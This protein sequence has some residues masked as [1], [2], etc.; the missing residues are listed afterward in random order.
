MDFG[1]MLQGVKDFLVG[2]PKNIPQP[3]AE[4]YDTEVFREYK[5][6]YD[7]VPDVSD[8]ELARITKCLSCPDPAPQQFDGT[9]EAWFL[10]ISIWGKISITANIAEKNTLSGKKVMTRNEFLTYVDDKPKNRV[11]GTWNDEVLNIDKVR[12]WRTFYTSQN[13][14]SKPITEEMIVS[15]DLRPDLKARLAKVR[16]KL[17]LKRFF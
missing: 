13:G 14:R 10:R 3:G 12:F 11:R 2:G 17:G 1:E 15:I 4:V 5:D 8:S 16:T 9:L 7:K 6:T